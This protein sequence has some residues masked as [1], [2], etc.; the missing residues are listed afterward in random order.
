MSD[1]TLYLSPEWDAILVIPDEKDDKPTLRCF[2][3]SITLASQVPYFR[4]LLRS[5]CREGLAVQNGAKPEILLKGNDPDAMRIILSFLHDRIERYNNLSPSDIISVAR[6][7]DKYAR[8]G[9]MSVYIYRWLLSL[10]EKAEPCEVGTCVAVACLFKRPEFIEKF[11]RMFLD[12]HTGSVADNAL[13][14]MQFCVGKGWTKDDIAIP[15]DIRDLFIQKAVRIMSEIT[16]MLDETQDEFMDDPAGPEYLLAFEKHKIWPFAPVDLISDLMI[17]LEAAARDDNVMQHSRCC[18]AI[19]ELCRRVL[20]L[21]VREQT[22]RG[23]DIMLELRC[24]RSMQAL[25]GPYEEPAIK[26]EEKELVTAYLDE[27]W[28]IDNQ[29]LMGSLA[30]YES[31]I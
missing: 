22:L 12:M 17:K 1:S 29:S 9:T 6:H 30:S 27:P 31:L 8:D 4:G 13:L 11:V 25:L 26:A 19:R 23:D 10:T 3:S 21:A 28:L 5:G 16:A 2:V 15:S 18:Q 24:T 7:Y 20:A 14:H